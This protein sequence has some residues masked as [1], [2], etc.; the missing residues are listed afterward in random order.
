MERFTKVLRTA[1]VAAM[2]TTPGLAGLTVQGSTAQG[3]TALG[4]AAPA[5]DPMLTRMFSHGA[6]PGMAVIVVR[7]TQVIYSRG[8]GWA[9][10]ES[11]K[12]FVPST[13]FY[14]AST[15]K[16]FTGLMAA[17][18][19]RAGAID[20]DATLARSLPGVALQAPLSA[21]A[22][23]LRDL[24]THTHGISNDG[25][26]VYRTAYSGEHTNELL[27]R[28]LALHGPDE[29]GR[30]F[31]YGNIGFNIASLVI[32]AA[33]RESW[34]DVE[35]RLLFRPLGMTSTTARRSEADA[36]RLAMPY[37]PSPESGHERLRYIKGD[38][39]MH[40]A[41]GILTT[42]QDLARWLEVHINEGVLDGRRVFDADV[43]REAHTPFAT[44]NGWAALMPRGLRRL[45]AFL[46][47]RG[48][49]RRHGYA[50]GW[51][52]GTLNGETILDHGG[53][54]PGFRTNLSFMPDRRIGIAVLVNDGAMGGPLGDDVTEYI[55]E[56]LIRGAS[57]DG[58]WQARVAAYPERVREAR[59]GIAADRARRAARPQT[60]PHPLEA[61]T[62]V[63]E[64]DALGRMEWRIRGGRLEVTAGLMTSDVEVYDGP[65]HRLRVELTGGGEVVEFLFRDG[66]VT[67]IRYAGRT[68]TKR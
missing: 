13:V 14:I 40:A 34:K 45:L 19:D 42:A 44:Q 46:G 63:F 55:Y 58:E 17:L 36:G 30:A 39:N 20:L 12:P 43:M 3:S 60:L 22:I 24:L 66:R 68:F 49:I 65:N 21:D 1:L 5:L 33:T 16:T 27:L 26:I 29:R 11:R 48:G 9:D 23:T 52:V 31:R 18:L 64:D 7:D 62:G 54:F 6:A 57:V 4:A 28:L 10:T 15:T 41:G 2:T 51:N 53:G 25:P 56:R 50:L 67:G 38:G 32:D 35:A 8:F 59:E 37:R 47:G 61:Y